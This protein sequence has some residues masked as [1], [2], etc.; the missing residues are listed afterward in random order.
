MNKPNFAYR[1][2]QVAKLLARENIDWL[3]L[4]P[5]ADF[6]YLTGSQIEDSRRLTALLLDRNG[7][8][9]LI[10]PSLE[11]GVF[12][13][14]SFEGAQDV[15]FWSDKDDPFNAIRQRLK[16]KPSVAVNGDLPARTLLRLQEVVG[17][18]RII[19]SDHII[20]TLRA[21]KD[22]Y[23]I[24]QLRVAAAAI[25][26]VHAQ[27]PK[28]LSAGRTERAVANDLSALMIEAGHAQ[29]AFVIVASGANAAEP[30][31]IPD[32]TLIEPNDLVVI[33]I[34]G[35]LPSGYHSDMTRMYLCG[36]PSAEQLRYHELVRAAQQL[37]VESAKPGVMASEVDEKARDYLSQN[38]LGEYCSH[39]VGHG[40]GLEVD[41]PPWLGTKDDVELQP[42]MVFSVEPGVYIPGEMGIRIEDV[43]LVT[44]DGFEVLT[45]GSHELVL[46]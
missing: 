27:V 34:G 17:P 32:E 40:I 9:H 38:E 1:Q 19:S 14:G 4:G 41:E 24:D 36:Q 13:S 23:E 39:R 22:P 28:I 21:R 18:S 35:P 6:T 2:E 15:I 31:H 44:D 42:G 16:G 25:S 8:S 10:A 43:V 5:G 26:W 46:I 29:S 7:Q 11:R 12:E 45:Q 20:G 30:H 3:V 33:D 37:G